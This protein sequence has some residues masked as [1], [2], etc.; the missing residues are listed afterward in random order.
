[1]S[2][3]T[4]GRSPLVYFVLA[5]FYSWLLWMPSI[6][7]GLGIEF[8]LDAETYTAITVPLGAFGPLAAALTLIARQHGWKEGWQF[9]RQAFDFKTKPIY[10][11]LALAIPLGYHVIA[12]YLAPLF[13]LQVANSLLGLAVPEGSSPWTIGFVLI[14]Y[15]LFILVLGGGQ[16]EFGWRGYAQIPLQ[17]RYGVIKASL[18]IGAVWGVWHLPLWIMPGDGHSTYSF[19]AFLIMIISQAIVYA[20]L[21]NASGQKL[22]IPLLFHAMQNTAMGPFPV[23][24]MIPG[25]PETAYWVFAGV[26]V[27]GGLIAAYFIRRRADLQ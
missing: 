13:K 11:L 18:L 21:Y 3:H 1:M 17:E 16:E 9:I 24:H 26:N 12:H 5:L 23:L 15:F 6:V 8:G 10:F 14:L 22:I 25:E 20:W 2:K 4:E 7:T 19:L 27:V